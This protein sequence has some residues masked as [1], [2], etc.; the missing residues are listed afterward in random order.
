VVF[1]AT[2]KNEILTDDIWICDSE[3][4]GR[5]C[6]SDKGLFEVKDINGKIILGNGESV[7]TTKIGNLKCHVTQLNNSSVNVT[8]RSQVCF[9]IVG[10]FVQYHQVIEERI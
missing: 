6:K 8:Q 1:T 7:K 3:A 10:G 2:S 5:Y 4:Y 9:R